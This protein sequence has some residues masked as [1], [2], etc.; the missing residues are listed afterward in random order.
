METSISLVM[1][2]LIVSTAVIPPASAVESVT[3]SPSVSETNAGN[4]MPIATVQPDVPEVVLI[5]YAEADIQSVLRSLAAK[6]GANLILSDDVTGKI[7]VRLEGVTYEDAMKLIVESKGFAYV[8]DKNVVRVKSRESLEVEPVE[9]KVHTLSYAKAED[10]KKTLDPMLT[11]QGRIQVDSRSNSLVVSDAISNMTKLFSLMQSLDT[12]TPQVMIEAKFVETTR[13]PKK[14]L[15]INWGGTLLNHEVAAGG[16]ALSDD[17]SKPPK[18]IVDDA[19]RPV[20]GFQW[21][22]PAGSSALTP[23]SAGVA[24]LDAGRASVTFSYLAQDENTELLANPRVVTTDNVKAKIAIG[25]QYPIPT[26]TY[27]ETKA[28]FQITGFDYRDIG[29]VLNVTPRVNKDN[30][31]TME[32]L[33]EVSDSKESANLQGVPI[34]IIL[35]R[36]TV[37]TVLVKSGNTLAIGGL[38]Q[39]DVSDKFT[40]VPILGS[41][42]FL[43]AFFRSK[44]LSKT[45][46]DLLIFLTP[47]IISADQINATGYEQYQHHAPTESY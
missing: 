19:N 23:W 46:R 11:K 16:S 36:Q 2:I 33:P 5:E 26:F 47:T 20:S 25:K 43:G 17:P 37:T 27:S 15:G 42:P 6:A 30:F 45:K 41:I 28:A 3:P 8:K 24:V 21:V 22:K 13:N 4:S 29:I 10:I 7:T 31:I 38:V 18:V 12:Q 14:D 32:V 9:V 1:V 40:K 34:P 44:S 35:T 39:Q